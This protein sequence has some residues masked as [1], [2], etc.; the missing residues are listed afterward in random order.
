MILIWSADKLL[1][2]GGSSMVA[3]IGAARKEMCNPTRLFWA[4][5]VYCTRYNGCELT[6]FHFA[7]DSNGSFRM[8][9]WN[10]TNSTIQKAWLPAGE[11]PLACWVLIHWVGLLCRDIVSSAFSTATRAVNKM[12]AKAKPTLRKKSLRQAHF[13]KKPGK[14]QFF[15]HF[16]GT[17]NRFISNDSYIIHSLVSCFLN[18]VLPSSKNTV[19]PSSDPYFHRQ[20]RHLTVFSSSVFRHVTELTAVTYISISCHDGWSMEVTYNFFLTI[21]DES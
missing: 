13:A 9:K 2:E 18:T 15:S 20:L 7:N 14:M 3:L 16:G 5:H 17:L 12:R 10:N 6:K 11:H 4:N 21:T 19:P 1:D 8:T